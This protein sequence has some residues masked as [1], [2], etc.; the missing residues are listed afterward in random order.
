MK[1][2]IDM[3]DLTDSKEVMMKKAP[4]SISVFIYILFAIIITALIWAG[5]GQM[6]I[7][8][9]ATGEVR[10][11]ALVATLTTP[12]TG[13]V[14]S[15][16]F[17]DGDTVE[18]G[19]VILD[20]DTE[21][22][23]EEKELLE[24]LL[25]QA[26]RKLEC[27]A[28]LKQSALEEKNLF[29]LSP[30]TELYYYQY[31]DYMSAINTQIEQINMENESVTDQIKE[32][33]Q[34]MELTQ[35]RVNTNNSLLESYNA[36]LNDI[37]NGIAYSGTDFQ[38]IMMYNS[39]KS[40]LDKAVITYNNYRYIYDQLKKEYDEQK[41]ETEGSETS[42]ILSS[43][44]QQITAEELEKAKFAMDSAEKDVEAVK[45]EFLLQINTTMEELKLSI[46]TDKDAIKSLKLQL[47]NL[48]E[49]DSIKEI[50][51]KA[52]NEF[53]LSLN[54][55]VQTI[56]SEIDNINKQLISINASAGNALLKAQTT[57][58]L[59]LNNEVMAGDI[60]S[61]GTQIG[62]IVPSN[63]ELKII[64]YIPESNIAE[65]QLGQKVEFVVSS[66]SMFEYGKI[67]GVID[68]ISVDSFT[69]DSSN[70]KYYKAEA[71]VE[72]NKLVNKK[73]EAKQIQTG[74]LVEARVIS[75]SQTILNWLLDRL[76]FNE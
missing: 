9:K 24:G 48:S 32:K 21:S 8:V 56:H 51:E 55:T 34:S 28:L 27:Y 63:E 39:Y 10:P 74:M 75:G 19:D 43:A 65:M 54:N 64:I 49:T 76:N 15:V 7:Y 25:T 69:N 42:E 18:T 22:I 16:N 33:K 71:I 60:I 13:K 53:L 73:G 38:L 3:E 4:L 2:I 23:I 66:I 46:S 35:N 57:G 68:S 1:T 58:T 37:S 70:Q 31:E 5:F 59:V 17:R 45:N 20:F 50:K 62:T 11:D 29:A 61:A 26:K 52:Q 30:D 6:D 72:S 12:N 47:E 40:S 41:N 67:K 44:E 14:R 36:L